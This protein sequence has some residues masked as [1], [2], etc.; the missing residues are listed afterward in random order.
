MGAIALLGAGGAGTALAAP[1]E[2]GGPAHRRAGLVDVHRYGPGIALDIRYATSRNVTG[3]RLSGYCR[4]WA[5]LLDPVARDLGRV[6]RRLRRRG[7]GL[8]VLDAYRPAR[9]SRALVRWARRTGR[10]HLVGTYIARRSNHN[11]GSAV[12]LTLV[13]R[14]DG[15]RAAHGP[16]RRPRPAGEHPQREREGAPQPPDPRPGH[17]PLRVR[18]LPP[19]VVALR[20]QDPRPALSGPGPWLLT[21]NGGMNTRPQPLRVAMAQMNPTV[22]DIAGN[23]RRISSLIAQAR[24]AGA[25]LVVLPELCLTGYPPEDLLLKTHFLEAADAA[26][27]ELATGVHGIVALVGFPDRAEDVFNAAAIL[28]EG[29]VAAVY[30]K[31]NLPNY[32][33]FDERRYFQAG[34]RPG[35]FE[36]NGIR[37]GVTIC[38]DIWEPGPPATAL[39]LHGAQ[40]LVNLSASPYHA[41]KGA[42]RERMLVQRA[43]D[44]LAAVLLCNTVGGQDELVFDGHSVALDQDG[45][46]LARAPQFEEALLTCTLDPGAVDAARLR[47]P[48]HRDAVLAERSSG[49]AGPQMLG[50][51]GVESAP[52]EVGG[53]VAEPLSPEEEVLRRAAHRPARLHAT[54]TAS[55]AWCSGSPAASTPRWWR[56]WPWMPWGPSG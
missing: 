15:K 16:L 47:D 21:H 51:F 29:E 11:L 13:R 40:V 42:E 18:E 44:N 45:E 24:D 32:G 5:L 4:P 41:G 27:Q 53:P 46:V 6:Q 52:S 22:G 56:S 43:R 1:D 33:V 48:R 26:L 2:A 9:G 34:A 19:R 31:M 12:D 8:S 38:E 39:A 10:G 35:L 3:K 17:V 55:I 28:A 36:L 54:R 50:S 20:P 37:I 25:Q 23:A 14:R 49:R 7:L 30:H